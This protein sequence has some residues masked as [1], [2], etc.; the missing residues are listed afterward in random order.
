MERVQ[1]GMGDFEINGALTIKELYEIAKK[2]GFED[3]ELF[4]SVKNPKTKQYFSTSHVVDFGKGWSK[5]TA[6]MHLEWGDIEELDSCPDYTNEEK[7]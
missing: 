3:R 2:G 6:I 1:N 4:F 5:S 7:G